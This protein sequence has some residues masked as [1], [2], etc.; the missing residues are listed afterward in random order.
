MDNFT[1]AYI[2]TALWSSNDDNGD[3]FDRHFSAQDIHPDTLQRIV[4]DCARFQAEQSTAIAKAIETGK[5][6]CGP[7]FDEYGRAGH[8]FWLTRCG[9]GAGFWD[10]DWPAPFDEQLSEAARAFG[11]CDLYVGDDGKLHI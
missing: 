9:H 7:D 3:P 10:G 5:V 2:T 11:N 4:E 8:D 1:K 6:A